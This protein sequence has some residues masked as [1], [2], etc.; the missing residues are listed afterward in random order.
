MWTV[1]LQVSFWCF[2][3]AVQYFEEVDLEGGEGEPKELIWLSECSEGLFL[4]E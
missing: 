1:A 2:D 3:V 4:C